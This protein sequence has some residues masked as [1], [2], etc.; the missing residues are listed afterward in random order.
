MSIKVENADK[1]VNSVY[2]CLTKSSVC[3]NSEPSEKY[4]PLF[5]KKLA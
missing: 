3:G 4:V 5:Y 2:I 1:R